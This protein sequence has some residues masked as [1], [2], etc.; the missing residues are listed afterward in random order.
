LY[1]PTGS[2]SAQDFMHKSPTAKGREERIGS[3]FQ[4]EIPVFQGTVAPV[5]LAAAT[6]PAVSASTTWNPHSQSSSSS[7][8]GAINANHANQAS[9]TAAAAAKAVKVDTSK[10]MWMP[11]PAR[12][13]NEGL[14]KETRMASYMVRAHEMIEQTRADMLRRYFESETATAKLNGLTVTQQQ[15][16]GGSVVTVTTTATAD[17][18]G[19]TGASKPAVEATDNS[20]VL[21]SGEYKIAIYQT[22]MER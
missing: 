21:L 22:F 4:A 8:S 16:A 20:F 1:S 13:V 14:W 18:P 15:K 3:S 2:F 5:K 12:N 10:P 17:A 9:A 19:A 6:G 7:S 11:P